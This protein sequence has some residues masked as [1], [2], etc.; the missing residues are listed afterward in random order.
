V[1]L[2][3][4]GYCATDLNA[5]AGYRTATQGAHSIL[6]VLGHGVADSGKMFFDNTDMGVKA[7]VPDEL[8]AVV[9]AGAP[10]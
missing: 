9:A 7:D 6:A 5:H 8:K 4:P 10:Q 1:L 3:C 2:S